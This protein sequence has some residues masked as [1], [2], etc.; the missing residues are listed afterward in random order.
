MENG[1]PESD[2]EVESEKKTWKT[3]SKIYRSNNSENGSTVSTETRK[4]PGTTIKE[5]IITVTVSAI[6]NHDKYT[7][8]GRVLD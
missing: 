8:R 5:I 7:W 6:L 4:K 3:N 2:L 1:Q